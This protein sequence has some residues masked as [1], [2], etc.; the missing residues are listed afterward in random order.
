M[1]LESQRGVS[2]KDIKTIKLANAKFIHN[3]IE[4]KGLFLQYLDPRHGK[5]LLHTMPG[6]TPEHNA[7]GR[8]PDHWES[9]PKQTS[10]FKTNKQI[11]SSV[12]ETLNLFSFRH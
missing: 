9:K 10:P 8:A 12:C 1:Q 5:W 3:L 6:V 2:C 11:S 7:I 4:I